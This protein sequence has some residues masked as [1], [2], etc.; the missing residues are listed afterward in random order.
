MQTEIE[1]NCLVIRIPREPPRPS[2]TGKTLIVATTGGNVETTAMVDGKPVIVGLNAYIRK[3]P[4][5]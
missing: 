3:G 1:N 4:T 2:S 5:A